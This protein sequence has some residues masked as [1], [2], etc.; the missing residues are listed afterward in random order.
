MGKLSICP[1]PHVKSYFY[2]IF[3]WDRT[4]TAHWFTVFLYPLPPRTLVLLPKPKWTRYLQ[5]TPS[6][7][8]HMNCRAFII[9]CGLLNRRNLNTDERVAVRFLD[10]FSRRA[11]IYTKLAANGGKC[12]GEPTS[13]TTTNAGGATEVLTTAARRTKITPSNGIKLTNP[14]VRA[15]PLHFRYRRCSCP[16]SFL[17]AKK[18]L[19]S[20]PPPIYAIVTVGGTCRPPP[21]SV[22]NATPGL[23]ILP[24]VPGRWLLLL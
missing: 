8:A 5:G 13:F 16:L 1:S 12:H 2:G 9:C 3:V 17:L 10:S 4:T 11:D 14:P 21:P 19:Y 15:P 24:I 18:E 20:P 23:L 22:A 6:T 7:V